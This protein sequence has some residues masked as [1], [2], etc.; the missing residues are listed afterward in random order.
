MKPN[1]MKKKPQ[2]VDENKE[3]EAENN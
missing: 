3:D 2:K 1:F